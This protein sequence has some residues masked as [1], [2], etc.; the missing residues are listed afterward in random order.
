MVELAHDNPAVADHRTARRRSR[1]PPP[2]A[3]WSPPTPPCST[4]TGRR[5]GRGSG[6][7]ASARTRRRAACPASCRPNTTAAA[8]TLATVST[9]VTVTT[10]NAAIPINEFGKPNADACG[11]VIT[12]PHATTGLRLHD[13]T[14]AGLI[15]I[16]IFSTVSVAEAI[17]PSTPATSIHHA[18]AAD[19]ILGCR[20]E[21]STG[22]SGLAAAVAVTAPLG[23]QP[24]RSRERLRRSL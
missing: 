9:P 11:V 1:R 5:C 12:D 10:A 7:S 16:S 22:S 21:S 15:R 20:L 24:S 6:R 13:G 18:P 14:Y 4:G 2:A 3:R 23:S 17:R 8:D 19:T